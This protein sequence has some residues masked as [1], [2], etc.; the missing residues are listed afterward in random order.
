MLGTRGLA[1]AGTS[2]GITM[3]INS[4]GNLWARIFTETSNVF[5]LQTGGVI[6]LNSWS[7][8]A[9]T[10]DSSTKTLK[11]YLNGTEAVLW[12]AQTLAVASTATLILEEHQLVHFMII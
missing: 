12:L 6:A 7:H 4:S 8:V 9:M 11:S 5:N 2:N 1:S 3:N 10:Y